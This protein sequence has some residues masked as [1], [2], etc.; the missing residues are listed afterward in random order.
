M[1]AVKVAPS[2]SRIFGAKYKPGTY[3]ARSH[4]HH[5]SP[6]QLLPARRHTYS[7][8]HGT[9]GDSIATAWAAI[10]HPQQLPRLLVLL[11]HLFHTGQG[12]SSPH[13]TVQAEAELPPPS[14]RADTAP[15][16]ALHHRAG[17]DVAGTARLR[18]GRPARHA[19][20]TTRQETWQH[21]PS[22]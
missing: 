20:S 5:I 9:E 11:T 10:P 19:A 21:H 18:P 13:N 15:R 14:S 22:N 2:A 3:K 8:S 17:G 12:L 6:A 4:L 1:A 16:P 7:P